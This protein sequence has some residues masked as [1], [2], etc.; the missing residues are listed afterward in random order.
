MGAGGADWGAMVSALA[1]TGV[2]AAGQVA[3][4]RFSVK[5]TR[6]AR[7]WQEMMAS[8]AY[9]RTVKD[10]RAAGLNPALAY[11]NLHPA[12]VP[13]T[14]VA[15]AFPVGKGM[16]EAMSSSAR[17]FAKLRSELGILKAT[18]SKAKSDAVAASNAAD[19]SQFDKH[20]AYNDMLER[21]NR[22]ELLGR[23]AS[24]TTAQQALIES[25]TTG[26]SY[27]NAVKKLDAEFYETDFGAKLRNF[28]RA[29]DSVSGL[30][31]FGV[32]AKR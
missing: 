3:A 31:R 30:A 32:K 25:Q 16:S 19:A 21:A 6:H 11:A 7:K 22:A 27:D 9:Q 23:Q 2:E 28:E 18:E 4:Q 13:Q 1:G 12:S 14:Q 24:S 5:Q 15:Q 20:R 17:G 26:R 8:T 29:V 10:L